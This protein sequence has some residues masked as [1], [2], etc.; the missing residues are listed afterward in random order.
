MAEA[1]LQPEFTTKLRS[2]VQLWPCS[3]WQYDWFHQFPTEESGCGELLSLSHPE[4]IKASHRALL[5]AGADAIVT[6]THG[7]TSLVMRDYGAADKVM[8]ANRESARL[9]FEACAE[10]GAE[11]LVVGS[12]GPTTTLLTLHHVPLSVVESAYFQQALA[13]WEAGVRI[14]HLE[15][16]QD[17]LNACA[18]LTA[19]A[20]V[21]NQTASTVMK[22]VTARVEPSGTMLLGTS[23][24][25][26]WELVRPFSPQAFGAI[27]RS[28]CVE[29]AILSLTTATDVPL[30]AMVD[31][32]AVASPEGWIESPE[33]L[34]KEL[35]ALQSQCNIRIAGTGIIPTPEY[36]R[37][38]AKA[39]R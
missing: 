26:F 22:V 23:L 4:L 34:C 18:A 16:C 15:G 6:N 32:F 19:L 9:A 11:A 31:T 29:E 38:L 2:R 5:N 30:I 37:S 13:L 10:V 17:P 36:I 28:K 21:E 8:E 1:L 25:S 35:V 3:L 39:L 12:M 33:S 27:G 24:N 7:A 14:F 20:Q